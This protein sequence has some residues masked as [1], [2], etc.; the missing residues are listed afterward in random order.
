MCDDTLACNAISTD[1]I[2]Y[3]IPNSYEDFIYIKTIAT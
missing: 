2:F 3:H 1:Y